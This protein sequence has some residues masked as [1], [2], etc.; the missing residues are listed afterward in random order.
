[1][2]ILKKNG[3]GDTLWKKPMTGQIFC[4]LQRPWSG[5]PYLIVSG[6]ACQRSHKSP[7]GITANDGEWAAL[8]LPLSH[9]VC[10]ILV[11]QMFRLK[12]L[13]KILPGSAPAPD[14][15]IHSLQ[16]PCGLGV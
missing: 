7:T 4:G 16:N 6:F 13:S 8:S 9:V 2:Y 12:Y 5:L 10:S 15:I 3:I 11:A 1:M 14:I